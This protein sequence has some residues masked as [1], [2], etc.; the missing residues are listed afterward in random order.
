MFF[1]ANKRGIPKKNIQIQEP[2]NEILREK[3]INEPNPL[4]NS[5]TN[6]LRYGMLAR[7][8]NTSGCSSCG[9]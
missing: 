3:N 8:S 6:L 1:S 9:K 5:T 4:I 7:L 2:K